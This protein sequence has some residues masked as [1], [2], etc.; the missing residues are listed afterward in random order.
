MNFT[1]CSETSVLLERLLLLSDQLLRFLQ[2]LTIVVLQPHRLHCW[3]RD[4]SL[5]V[6]VRLIQQVQATIT[7]QPFVPPWWII[8]P[9]LLSL[10][11]L[12]PPPYFVSPRPLTP[13]P[14]SLQ[15]LFLPVDLFSFTLPLPLLSPPSLFSSLGSHP[16][17]AAPTQ[18]QMAPRSDLS[19][20]VEPSAKGHSLKSWPIN[21]PTPDT[22]SH[23]FFRLLSLCVCLTTCVRV[24]LSR[25]VCSYPCVYLRCMRGSERRALGVTNRRAVP[26]TVL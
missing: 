9:V 12:R 2:L 8:A 7:L 18:T 6:V 22:S 21:G 17:V 26:Q 25:C 13:L 10:L 14:S 20:P 11:L 1:I 5:S 15:N 19:R 24:C 16:R 3:S 23:V 4:M